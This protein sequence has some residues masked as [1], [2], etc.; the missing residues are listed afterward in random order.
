MD[1]DASG[2]AHRT[3]DRAPTSRAGYERYEISNYAQAGQEAIHN[4]LY[5]VGGSIPGLG[6]GAHSYLP[7]RG[8]W[9]AQSVESNV[10]RSRRSTSRRSRNGTI[11]RSSFEERL[12]PDGRW[13]QTGSGSGL[14]AAWGID[15]EDSL[16]R[17]A[18]PRRISSSRRSRPCAGPAETREGWTRARRDAES[19]ETDRARVSCS[20]T[21]SRGP[22]A[23]GAVASGP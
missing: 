10:R 8:G 19:G 2:R 1:D 11:S 7:A 12:N 13:S 18:R 16:L 6:A 5:W 14:R 17:E 20:T 9:R 22:S 23:S 3:G 21:R 4:N 15:L